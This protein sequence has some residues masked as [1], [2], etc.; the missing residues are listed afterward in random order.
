VMGVSEWISVI[1]FGKKI[2]EGVPADIQ[3][4]PAVIEAYLG[5][6]Q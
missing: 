1:N 4:D 6:E 5:K 2:A 3:R